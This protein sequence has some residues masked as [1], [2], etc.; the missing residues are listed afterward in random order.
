MWVWLWLPSNSI[1]WSPLAE[2][3]VGHKLP[4]HRCIQGNARV[5]VVIS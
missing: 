1:Q 4:I 3:S 5:G 2:V